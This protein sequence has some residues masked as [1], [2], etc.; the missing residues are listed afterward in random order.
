MPNYA[1]QEQNQDMVSL[2]SAYFRLLYNPAHAMSD[3]ISMLRM[4]PGLVGLWPGWV[5]DGSGN[6]VD[7]SGNA[8]H[9]TRTSTLVDASATQLFSRL[10]MSA[11]TSNASHVDA[12]IFDILGTETHIASGIRGLTFGVWINTPSLAATQ[13]IMSKYLSAADRAYWVDVDTS[14]NAR[15]NISNTGADSFTVSLSGIAINSYYL[16]VCRF[17]PSTELKVWINGNTNVNT[18]SIPASIFNSSGPFRLGQRG[19]T[20]ATAA[21]LRM[22]NPFVCAAYVPDQFITAYY[23]MTAPLFGISI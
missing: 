15:F 17:D 9:L 20:A 4:F 3:A 2:L 16:I 19:D 21:G 5:T 13:Q 12:A 6:V 11:T 22:L 7:V 8:N 23:Q 14:G 10:F 1:V 18:T